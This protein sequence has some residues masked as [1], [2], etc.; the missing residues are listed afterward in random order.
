MKSLMAVPEHGRVMEAASA[1]ETNPM[2][3]LFLTASWVSQVSDLRHDIRASV[4]RETYT[5][6]L[7][8]F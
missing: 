6:R 4:G 8:K 1:I 3:Q 7:L 2:N 5:T